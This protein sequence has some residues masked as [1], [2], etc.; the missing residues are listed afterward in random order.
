MSVT[1]SAIEAKFI[2]AYQADKP[3]FVVNNILT[4]SGYSGQTNKWYRQAG[5]SVTEPTFDSAGTA[6]L[7]DSTALPIRYTHDNRSALF[8]SPATG[9]ANNT[10]Y[11]GLY[12]CKWNTITGASYSEYPQAFYAD[13]VV[14]KASAWGEGTLGTSGGLPNSTIGITA[15][16]S[17]AT[18]FSS[19]YA[20]MNN[21]VYA[22]DP[23]TNPNPIKT[24]VSHTTS[25]VVPASGNNRYL[26]NGNAYVRIEYEQ[27]GGSD[28][29]ASDLKIGEV[30]IGE[31]I[32][33]SRNTNQPYATEL[34]YM[35][36]STDFES[37]RGDVVRYVRAKGRR[38]FELDFTP[39]GD[40]TYGI[41]DLEQFR[42]LAKK[43]GQFTRPFM[44]LPKPYTEPNNAYFVYAEDASFNMEAVGPF[45]RSVS[46][47]LVEIPPFV[48]YQTGV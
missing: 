44:Y 13:T 28:Y 31:R 1:E 39:T 33:L 2:S 21:T 47:S 26:I 4:G 22:D 23:D 10:N 3:C 24:G 19:P 8:S 29:W 34:A 16:I 43:T 46:L 36:D 37:S 40:D 17:A 38:R 32:Q 5:G 12:A 11:W 41:D 42:L 20:L 14:I 18:D 48:D 27:K 6:T 35:N 15:T 45:E 9:S 30:F 7:A 25:E